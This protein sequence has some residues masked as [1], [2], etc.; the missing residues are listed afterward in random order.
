LFSEVELLVHFHI[1]N[2]HY[3]VEIEI[4]NIYYQITTAMNHSQN[5]KLKLTIITEKP[6]SQLGHIEVLKSNMIINKT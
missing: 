1:L 2:Q 3:R 5:E 6:K 4:L